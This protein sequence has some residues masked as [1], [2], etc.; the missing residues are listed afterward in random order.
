MHEQKK[1]IF[2]CSVTT[3]KVEHKMLYMK[4]P[5]QG[6]KNLHGSPLISMHMVADPRKMPG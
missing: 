5:A 4:L 6:D 3:T 2:A 1:N